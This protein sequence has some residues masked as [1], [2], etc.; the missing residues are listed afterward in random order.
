[1]LYTCT[2]FIFIFLSKN[3]TQT[4]EQYLLTYLANRQLNEYEPCALHFPYNVKECQYAQNRYHLLLAYN[5]MASSDLACGSDTKI[6]LIN[7]SKLYSYNDKKSSTVNLCSKTRVMYKLVC[8][9]MIRLKSKIDLTN[10]SKLC[11]Y[12]DK[13]S[14]TVNLCSKTRVTYTSM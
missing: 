14:S 7:L 3:E 4:Y 12:N 2:N 1:M 9:F 8:K 13:K 11:S 6:D 5:N 10:L